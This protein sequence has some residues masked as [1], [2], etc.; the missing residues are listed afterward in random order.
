MSQGTRILAQRQGA[1]RH[2]QCSHRSPMVLVS[3]ILRPH[4]YDPQMEMAR[5]YLTVIDSVSV[6]LLGDV[7]AH[8]VG[9]TTVF[10][11]LWRKVSAGQRCAAAVGDKLE[12]VGARLEDA[13]LHAEEPER[14]AVDGGRGSQSRRPWRKVFEALYRRTSVASVDD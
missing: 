6:L 10:S 5:R 8:E 1:Y 9:P 13:K 11:L 4:Y 7:P 2:V 14:E 12:D 3:M